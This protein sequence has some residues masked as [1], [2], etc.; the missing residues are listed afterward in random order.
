MFDR[1]RIHTLAKLR[2]KLHCGHVFHKTCIQQVKRSVAAAVC[3]NCILDT[4]EEQLLRVQYSDKKLY[5][6][7]ENADD[8]EMGWTYRTGM[9]PLFYF[10]LEHT[11]VLKEEMESGHKELVLKI[12]LNVIAF[13][14]NT[15]LDRISNWR[16]LC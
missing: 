7:L 6:L 4:N 9:Q 2:E 8:R 11:N 10:I 15:F 3:P 13:Q 14:G 5:D 12:I 1:K 16:R